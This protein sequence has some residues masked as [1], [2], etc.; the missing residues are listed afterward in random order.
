[1]DALYLSYITNFP[2]VVRIIFCSVTIMLPS[3]ASCTEQ[4]KR[5]L[6]TEWRRYVIV[7]AW[8]VLRQITISMYM[9]EHYELIRFLPSSVPRHIMWL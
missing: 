6:D 4:I 1:M 9:Y 2:Q 5:G 8:Q 3:V 7:R